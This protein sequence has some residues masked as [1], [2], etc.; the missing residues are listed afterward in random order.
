MVLAMRKLLQEK[1]NRKNSS[2]Q[3][4][5]QDFGVLALAQGQRRLSLEHSRV[6]RHQGLAIDL[7]RTA[8]QKNIG[9]AGWVQGEYDIFR[10]I[11]QA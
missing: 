5:Y 7:Q 3:I 9:F 6:A 10:T 1:D 8:H 11:E 2:G 4:E